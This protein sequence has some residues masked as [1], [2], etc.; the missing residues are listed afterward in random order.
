MSATA[1]STGLAQTR[2][3]LLADVD[4]TER[5]LRLAGVSTAVLEGGEGPPL[6]L[7]HGGIECGGAIGRR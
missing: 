5:R 2:Q 3:R 4:V 7:L 6:V 1:R